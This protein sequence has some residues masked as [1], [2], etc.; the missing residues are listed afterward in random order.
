MFKLVK[1]LKS[2]EPDHCDFLATFSDYFNKFDVDEVKNNHPWM[3]S[4]L[5]LNPFIALKN[6]INLN[7]LHNDMYECPY[8]NMTFFRIVPDFIIAKDIKKYEEFFPK[9]M[10]D[11]IMDKEWTIKMSLIDT[12]GTFYRSPNKFQKVLLGPGYDLGCLTSDGSNKIVPITI[13]ISNGDKLVC[14]TYE[15]YNK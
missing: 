7:I 9:Y 11:M 3:S 6:I 12:K 14:W 1:P 10:K 2:Y 5:N 8:T 15:W 13:N 4:N